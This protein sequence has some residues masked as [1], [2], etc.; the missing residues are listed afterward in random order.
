LRALRVTPARQLALFIG[1]AAPPASR[2]AGLP[3]HARG[4]VLA[5]LARIIARGVLADGGQ[6]PA[7]AADEGAVG[8]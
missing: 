1:Q 3:E 8:D 6:A 5:L 4:E 7:P 2:W